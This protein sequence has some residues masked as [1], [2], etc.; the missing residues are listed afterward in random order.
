MEF[1][2]SLEN[3]AKIAEREGFSREA[4]AL[5]ALLSNMY[6]LTPWKTTDSGLMFR[7]TRTRQ[8]IILALIEPSEDGYLV[9]TSPT[10]STGVETDSVVVEDLTTALQV[11]DEA[12][13]GTPFIVT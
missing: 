6:T 10:F 4:E 7:T 2:S 1:S 13:E 3:I 9:T 8:D 12:F 5:S 11:A